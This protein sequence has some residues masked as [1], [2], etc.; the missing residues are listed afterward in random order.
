M[1]LEAHRPKR[2][3]IKAKLLSRW[4]KRMGVLSLASTGPLRS[5][6]PFPFGRLSGWW[7]VQTT[8]PVDFLPENGQNTSTARCFRVSHGWFHRSHEGSGSCSSF[9]EGI[10]NE[11]RLFCNGTP[12]WKAV[13]KGTRPELPSLRPRGF[14]ECL[15]LGAEARAGADARTSSRSSC[16]RWRSRSCRQEQS[17]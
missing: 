10:R 6:H 1:C 5:N 15:V 11:R 9:W 17:K 4:G 16:S 2:L 7:P 8:E 3:T 13:L 14:D 12:V